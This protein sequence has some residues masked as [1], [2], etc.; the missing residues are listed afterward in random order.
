[1][2]I[3][4]QTGGAYHDVLEAATWAEG[5]NLSTF[6]VPDHYVSGLADTGKGTGDAFDAFALLAG[7]ARETAF[8][9]LAVLV[10]PI[11]FRHP[12]V[13][14]K[15]AVTID[16]M[17]GG[18]F[19]LGIGTGWHEREHE[20][21]GLPFPVRARRFEMM[22]EALAYT[23]AAFHSGAPGYAG[24]VFHLEAVAVE[25]APRGALPLIVGGVGDH[26]TPRLAGRFADEYNV[27]PAEP[28][29]MAA[30]I[31]RMRKAAQAAG[32]DPDQILLSSAGQ[33]LTAPTRQEYEALFRTRA[34][35]SGIDPEALEQ[36]YED[37]QTPRG[38]LDQVLEQISDLSRLG[39]SRFYL[40]RFTTTDR[41][42]YE[43]LI[44]AL[45]DL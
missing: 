43:P 28:A 37:R 7:L 42:S 39:V 44:A 18:R 6:A 2:E 5:H 34:A 4:L 19:A 40:Q 1:M 45:R 23:R 3:G 30:R 12:A 31:V 38:P 20:I 22:E 11:T 10:T 25:P 36:H 24:E 33:V 13:I 15:N 17:S 26:V 9:Q 32:R 8:I 29:R 21:F 35:E 41:T 14:V 27:Y 16:H